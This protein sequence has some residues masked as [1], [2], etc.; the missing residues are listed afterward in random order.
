MPL[1]MA[2]HKTQKKPRSPE[3]EAQGARPISMG[4]MTLSARL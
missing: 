4:A 1:K 3:E 2:S